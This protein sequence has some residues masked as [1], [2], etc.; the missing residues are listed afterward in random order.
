MVHYENEIP[1][2]LIDNLAPPRQHSGRSLTI[3][4]TDTVVRN[5]MRTRKKRRAYREMGMTH[6]NEVIEDKKSMLS[7]YGRQT[8][9]KLAGLLAFPKMEYL[10]DGAG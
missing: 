6:F 2:L 7:H 8:C 1:S 10:G 3:L 4:P 9:F 5:I